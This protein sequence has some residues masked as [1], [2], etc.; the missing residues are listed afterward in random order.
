[1][2]PST[3][4]IETLEPKIHD[5]REASS[6]L[7]VN[8]QIVLAAL[9]SPDWRSWLIWLHRS[10][11]TFAATAFVSSPSVC[12][13]SAFDLNTCPADH[14]AAIQHELV[15][16][17]LFHLHHPRC[18]PSSSFV[19][20]PPSS[21]RMAAVR[22]ETDFEFT[23]DK[24]CVQVTSGDNLQFAVSYSEPYTYPI[25]AT[26]DLSSTDYHRLLP[27]IHGL[28]IACLFRTPSPD[29]LI[30]SSL[31]SHSVTKFSACDS[32][33]LPQ[34]YRNPF[35]S[36]CE[37]MEE[38]KTSINPHDSEELWDPLSI[39][40]GVAFS[41]DLI[42]RAE[43]L[44]RA[45]S[46]SIITTRQHFIIAL[47]KRLRLLI[48]KL[49]NGNNST[50]Y[51]DGKLVHS[52]ISR[53]L[54]LLLHMMNLVYIAAG[55]PVNSSPTHTKFL[56]PGSYFQIQEQQPQPI[57]GI[58]MLGSYPLSLNFSSPSGPI[59][60]PLFSSIRD[61]YLLEP[62]KSHKSG[63]ATLTN[64]RRAVN[65]HAIPKASYQHIYH[66]SGNISNM[67]G[68][69]ANGAL[70][71]V[72]S[73]L[74]IETGSLLT[75]DHRS[76]WPELSQAA[77]QTLLLALLSAAASAPNYGAL[78]FNILGG[79]SLDKNL[80]DTSSKNI[81]ETLTQPL[82]TTILSLSRRSCNISQSIMWLHLVDL[83]YCL[84]AKPWASWLFISSILAS[85]VP[86]FKESV[87]FNSLAVSPDL[88]ASVASSVSLDL[89]IT[90]FRTVP[91]HLIP[92]LSIPIS[93]RLSTWVE[94]LLARLFNCLSAISGTVDQLIYRI[95]LGQ[96]GFLIDAKG[97]PLSVDA[98]IKDERPSENLLNAQQITTIHLK[99][100][101]ARYT[102]MILAF[103]L[104]SLLLPRT[105][106][107]QDIGLSLWRLLDTS[108]QLHLSA[109]L[110]SEHI[111]PSSAY[112]E[113]SEQG[114]VNRII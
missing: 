81:S 66:S 50:T 94:Q 110:S 68:L 46:Y 86:R 55:L 99:T 111:K 31:C 18:Q 1:P 97:D 29:F 45:V 101:W 22:M 88:L 9:A 17:L 8:W 38:P 65:N 7:S 102:E 30:S 10:T 5:S 62:N 11:S 4:L 61:Q 3:I 44:P 72:Q 93:G 24:D 98:L 43:R 57:N 40:F 103:R 105:P 16:H 85:K 64:C 67:A 25:E 90:F 15:T 41:W 59:F 108:V 112:V 35:H 39:L 87:C 71:L 73:L 100:L 56:P 107:R 2:L 42:V 32:S 77:Q 54:L 26:N 79:R 19:P 89:S 48:S 106:P 70:G 113:T 23:K 27:S 28:A 69:I 60:V 6:F 75:S 58:H 47:L 80:F 13:T 91:L 63:A 51:G 52:T 104:L 12:Q 78:G 83:L 14:L 34:A 114:K 109:A 76:I 49:Q 53:D 20:L 74:R 36:G 21:D 84:Q 82:P 33:H 92:P 95:T 96:S 37:V